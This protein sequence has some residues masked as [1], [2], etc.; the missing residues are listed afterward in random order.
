MMINHNTLLYNLLDRTVNIDFQNNIW[1]ANYTEGD[2]FELV[3]KLND[4]KSKLPTAYPIIWL[5][6]TYTVERRKQEGITKLTNCKFFLITLGSK[7]ARY[8]NRFDSTYEHMLYPLLN[9]MDE[10]FRKTKGITAADNDSYMVFPLNDVAK[11]QNGN[12]IPELTA[13]TEVWD[14]VLFETDLTITNDC[15][16]DLIIKKK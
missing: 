4:A 13:I 2:L 7:T 10:K 16:P 14:A 11:D 9:E 15:F 12:P 5:Q 3:A 8:K 1:I 6:S